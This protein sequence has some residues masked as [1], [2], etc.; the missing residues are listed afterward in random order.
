M[1]N[2]QLQGTSLVLQ[3][4]SLVLLIGLPVSSSSVLECVYQMS[5]THATLTVSIH[6][7]LSEQQLNQ[8]S[9]GPVSTQVCPHPS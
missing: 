9:P 2:L 8:P 6:D 1:C 3:G 4:T 5:N 7:H